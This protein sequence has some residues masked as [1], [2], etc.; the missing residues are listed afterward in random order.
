MQII[1]F[2]DAKH[3]KGGSKSQK[4]NLCRSLSSTSVFESEEMKPSHGSSLTLA[5]D[6]SS[7]WSLLTVLAVLTVL[8]VGDRLGVEV[9]LAQ[10]RVD[11]LLDRKH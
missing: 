9:G 10:G 8:C 1:W 11:Q 4:L 6:V 5:T 2:H 3:P 7:L